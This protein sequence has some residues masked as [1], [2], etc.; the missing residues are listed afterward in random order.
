MVNHYLALTCMIHH[1][2]SALCEQ[3]LKRVHS[4]LKLRGL[5]AWDPVIVFKLFSHYILLA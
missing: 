1:R 2:L 5:V 3:M 4:H